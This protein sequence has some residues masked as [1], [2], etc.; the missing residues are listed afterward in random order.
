MLKKMIIG[1]TALLVS[2][3]LMAQT[4][5]NNEAVNPQAC[6]DFTNVDI[7][8]LRSKE[9]INLCD[10]KNKPL[11]IVNTASNCGFTPQFESLEKLHKTYKDE[12]LVILGFPSDDFFQEED[13]EKETAKVCFINYGVTFPMFATSEVRGSDANPIFKH[14]NEQTSS[15]NWNFYKYLVSADRKTILRFN[16][17]VKPDSEKMIKAVENSL[18]KI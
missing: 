8:K 9:S 4:Q 3:T 13:N 5:P 15:P 7:R 1:F 16:S 11:L 18:S 17:K 14:L 2:S 12:G 6:D 10:Y